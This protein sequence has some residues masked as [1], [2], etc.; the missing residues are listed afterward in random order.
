[1][2]GLG[3]LHPGPTPPILPTQMYK[4]VYVTQFHE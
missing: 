4:Q 3:E 2:T 1:M